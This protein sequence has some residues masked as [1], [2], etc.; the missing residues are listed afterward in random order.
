MAVNIP[1]VNAPN[2]YVDNLELAWASATTLTMAAGAAR[3][4]TN[5]NDIILSS[6]VTI[7]AAVNG[8]N[9]LDA[10]SLGNNTFYAVHVIG[11]SFGNNDAAGMLSTSATAPVL[12]GGYDMFRRVGWVLT[13]GAAAILAF[14]QYG[15]DKTRDMYYDV[16]ISELSGGNA[17]A[18][19]AINLASSVPTTA[20]QVRFD[21][22][23]T[24]AGA[25]NVASFIPGGS[26]ATNGIVRFGTGVAGAQV[27]SIM[28]P[29]ELVASVPTV[30]YKVSA[31]GDALTLLCTGYVDYL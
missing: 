14:W 18:F 13:S 28:V 23:Y 15:S 24:P 11:D 4:S 29:M 6:A 27:D 26:S 5:A 22:A 7:N 16:G 10:G 3:D 19:T 8:A 17:T 1:V 31:G 21:I 9:G 20:G 30:Q 2:L 12:P 25:T